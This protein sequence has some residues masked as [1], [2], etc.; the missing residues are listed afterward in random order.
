MPDTNAQTFSTWIDKQGMDKV[1]KTLKVHRT[2]VHYWRAGSSMP[3]AKYMK[4]IHKA[5]RGKVSYEGM[6]R[7]FLKHNPKI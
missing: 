3:G 2:T 5:S 7:H 1:A 6:V 4:R